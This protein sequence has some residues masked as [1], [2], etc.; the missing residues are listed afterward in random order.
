M[1]TV[2]VDWL[3]KV[4]DLILQVIPSIQGKDTNRKHNTI[5]IMTIKM[6]I[7]VTLMGPGK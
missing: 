2:Q 1:S 5:P 6:E 3:R 4:L 7:H